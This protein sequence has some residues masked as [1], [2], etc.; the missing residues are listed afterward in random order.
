MGVVEYQSN[1]KVPMF[2]CLIV[3]A[4]LI[5][6]TLIYVRLAGGLTGY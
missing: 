6:T 4:A 5:L 1:R 2:D 3:T